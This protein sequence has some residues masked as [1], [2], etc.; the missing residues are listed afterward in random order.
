MDIHEKQSLA[1][2][3]RWRAFQYTTLIVCILGILGNVS[4]LNVLIRH[5][6]EIAGSRLLLALA[7]ADLG[8]VISVAS[9]T[10]AYVTYN[11]WL[12]QVLDWWFLYCYYCSIYLTVLLSLDRYL[13]TAKPMLLIRINYQKILKRAIFGVFAAMLLI[14]FPSFLAIF[15]QYHYGTHLGYVILSVECPIKESCMSSSLPHFYTSCQSPLDSDK[16]WRFTNLSETEVE[17][18]KAIKAELCGMSK[19]YNYTSHAC[20]GHLIQ[21]PATKFEP[22]VNIKFWDSSVNI[23]EVCRVG[24]AAMRYD[25][26]FVKAVYLG[27][28]L[29]FRY[30]IPSCVLVF[31]N[32]TLVVSV[33]RAQR[34]HSD[35]SGAPRKSLL[36]LPVFRSA[37]AIAFVFLLCHTGG[38][39]IFVLDVFRVFADSNKGGL[40]TTVKLFIDEQLATMGLEM[41]YSGIFLAAVNSSVNVVLYC[42]FLPA[43]RQHWASLFLP[44]FRKHWASVFKCNWKRKRKNRS[45]GEDIVPMEEMELSNLGVSSCYKFLLG[46]SF[47]F[48]CLKLIKFAVVL[49]ACADM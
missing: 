33:V 26:D 12:T 9:R 1:P 45:R 24:K 14:T 43:F 8:V 40:G 17:V 34:H 7:V 44:A 49:H 20:G 47:N 42:F 11:N 28:D 35:I 21:I 37:V 25:S 19:K 38:A 4:S 29:P 48:V 31:L 2:A 39:G 6:K 41:K 18:Y 46:K 13:H 30:V 10:L 15:V 36:N 3:E 5:L 32:I 22:N 23:V 16:G 27:I